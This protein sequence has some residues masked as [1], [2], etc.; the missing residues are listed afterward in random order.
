MLELG[1]NN[2]NGT[3]FQYPRLEKITS[4]STFFLKILHHNRGFVLNHN[5]KN[6]SVYT[7]IV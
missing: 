7:E 3:P 1:V 6:Q 2:I 4:L 5:I